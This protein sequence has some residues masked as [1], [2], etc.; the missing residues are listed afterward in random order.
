M[1]LSCELFLL[2][3]AA[4]SADCCFFI[5]YQEKMYLCTSFKIG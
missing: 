1:F 4:N 5:L 3:L 2:F